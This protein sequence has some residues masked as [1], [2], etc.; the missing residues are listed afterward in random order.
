MNLLH[1]HTHTKK[2]MNAFLLMGFG[3]FAFTSFSVW[4]T[5]LCVIY[6]QQQWYFSDYQKQKQI[7]TKS[8]SK[9][10]RSVLRVTPVF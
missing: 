4:W 8:K 3:L 10:K 9:P 6:Q 2:S 5:L 7:K 1:A